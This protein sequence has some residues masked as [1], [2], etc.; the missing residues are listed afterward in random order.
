MSTGNLG[1]ELKGIVKDAVNNRDFN[2]L[3]RDIKNVVNS[4]FEEVRRSINTNQEN[5]NNRI[6]RSWTNNT[7][8]RQEGH[9]SNNNSSNKF[10]NSHGNFNNPANNY[11]QGYGISKS[12]KR[13]IFTVPVGQV[14]GILLTVFGVL[15]NS[16]FGIGALVLAILGFAVPGTGVL[17]KV[18]LGLAVAFM[19]SLILSM[20]GK[21]IRNRL[22]RFKRYVFQMHGR[23]YCLISDLASATGFSNRYTAKDLRKM[24]SIGMFPQGRID[25][26]KTCFMLN[27]ESY[28]QYLRLQKNMRNKALEELKKSEYRAM[29]PGS[30]KVEKSKKDLLKPEER[31]VID[32]GRQF[33]LDIKNANIEIPG[34]EIS[35]KLDRLEEV[36]GKIYDFVEE[37]PEKFREIK[38]FSEYFLPTTLKLLDAYRELDDQLVKGDNILSAKTEIEETMDTINLAFENLLDGFF[39]DVALDIS[40]DISV[41]ETMFAQEGLTERN[42]SISN[43]QGGT[44]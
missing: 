10:Y 42:M 20:N 39:E 34:E 30:I 7:G 2:K 27:N 43:K 25:E 31:K 36:T 22:K 8:N 41:L 17:H 1:E 13:T 23:N 24:I 32:E 19:G 16:L 4:A 28:E 21:R 26:K 6:N 18:A 11:K 33:V 5:S 15:G 14:S 3:N 38:K 44:K 9:H 12:P 37:H 35:M 40:T 29:A